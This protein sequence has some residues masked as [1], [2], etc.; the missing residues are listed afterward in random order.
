MLKPARVMVCLMVLSCGTLCAWIFAQSPAASTAP[1]DTAAD[2]KPAFAAMDYFDMNC[3]RCHGPQGSFYGKQFGQHLT[4][5]VLTKFVKDMAEG[6]GNAPLQEDDLKVEVAYHRALVAGE[7]FVSVTGNDNG[8]LSGEVSPGSSVTIDGKAAT[9]EGM[10][11]SGPKGALIVAV[12]DQKK[13]T[14]RTEDR[15]SHQKALGK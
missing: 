14:L 12:R 8:T 6:P 13:T 15:Y 11:W 5:A 10:K 3:A 2:F 1:A 4:D 9:V 7:P